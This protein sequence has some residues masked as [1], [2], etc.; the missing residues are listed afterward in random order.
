[1]GGNRR[2]GGFTMIE[3]LTVIVIIMLVMALALPDFVHMMKERKWGAAIANIQAMVMRTRAL[4]TNVRQD[5][6]V[7]FNIQGDNGTTMW[8]E[9]KNNDLETIPDLW[10]LEHEVGGYAP[11]YGFM[12]TVFQDA[13]GTWQKPLT[14]YTCA[15]CGHIWTDNSYSGTSGFCRVAKPDLRAL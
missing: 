15:Q 6:S 3:M 5:F 13:G 4:A 1:M 11:I 8:I 7:E 10:T 12:T 14:E 9:S 2:A